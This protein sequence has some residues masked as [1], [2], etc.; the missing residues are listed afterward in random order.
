M[1]E[2]ASMGPRSGERGKIEGDIEIFNPLAGLQW[3]RVLV[4]AESLGSGIHGRPSLRASMGPRSGERGK[5]PFNSGSA[6][7]R[8]ASMGPRSGERGKEGQ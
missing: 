1:N 6:A 4:N 7:A 8:E 2:Q 3:G 5:H